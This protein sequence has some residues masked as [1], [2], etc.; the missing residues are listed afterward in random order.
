MDMETYE[1]D[2]WE[3]FELLNNKKVFIIGF[4]CFSIIA[5]FLISNFFIEKQYQSEA[6]IKLNDNFLYQQNETPFDYL[7]TYFMNPEITQFAFDD[8]LMI[9][10][11]FTDRFSLK[12]IDSMLKVE[13]THPYRSN[14][15]EKL[16]KLLNAT[17]VKLIFDEGSRVVLTMENEILANQMIIQNMQ[18][19][20]DTLNKA[21]KKEDQYVLTEVFPKDAINPQTYVYKEINP[22]YTELKTKATQIDIEITSIKNQNDLLHNILSNYRSILKNIKS[23]NVFENND[24]NKLN[25]VQTNYVTYLNEIRALNRTSLNANNQSASYNS[26]IPFEIITKPTTTANPIGPNVKLNIAIVSFLALF[27]SV[28]FVFFLNYLEVVKRE[29]AT[30]KINVNF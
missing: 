19:K 30:K 23:S 8:D 7:R 26:L 20:L 18:Y 21:L 11:R 28:F 17:R 27:I 22:S 1:I 6:W 3:F 9:L 16:L 25:E 29:K 2:L 12:K 4:V 10:N 13:L 5:T 14:I 24:L 15:S